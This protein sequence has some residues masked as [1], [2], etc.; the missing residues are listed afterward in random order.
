MR[1]R[2]DIP[3]TFA[4]FDV[5][6]F[7]GPYTPPTITQRVNRIDEFSCAH[8]QD[9]VSEYLSRCRSLVVSRRTQLAKLTNF[10][11]EG[12]RLT[13]DVIN[14]G[15]GDLANFADLAYGHWGKAAALKHFT[16]PP[17]QTWFCSCRR[18]ARSDLDAG[19]CWHAQS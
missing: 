2:A 15:D 4:S 11:P 3:T 18:S 6:L 16:A 7:P 10:A 5:C 14:I 19:A 8:T 12:V 9:S 13:E 1:Q 17:P